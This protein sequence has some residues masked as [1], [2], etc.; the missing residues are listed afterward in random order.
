MTLCVGTRDSTASF[1]LCA[2]DLAFAKGIVDGVPRGVPLFTFQ[3]ASA[4]EFHALGARDV[5]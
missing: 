5:R 2:S 3:L 4:P 1:L